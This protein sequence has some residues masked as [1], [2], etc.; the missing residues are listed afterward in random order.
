VS[1][2]ELEIQAIVE[3]QTEQSDNPFAGL[4]NYE[5]ITPCPA[6]LDL[7]KQ[8][9]ER[10][11]ILFALVERVDFIDPRHPGFKANGPWLSFARH[12]SSCENCNEV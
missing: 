9:G 10:S 2:P 3:E 12:Y 8:F 4:M 6:G 5:G 1:E 11:P 7:L